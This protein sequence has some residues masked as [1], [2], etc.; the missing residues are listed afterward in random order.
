[1]PVLNLNI[2]VAKIVQIYLE[3]IRINNSTTRCLS[4][5][6]IKIVIYYKGAMI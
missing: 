3:H 4:T 1:M 6:W 2:S 5:N